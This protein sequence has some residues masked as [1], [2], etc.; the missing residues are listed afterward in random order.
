MEHELRE[1][2]KIKPVQIT[3]S[4][5]QIDTER[6]TFKVCT[7]EGLRIVA[8]Y[9]EE[10]KHRVIAVL[11]DPENRLIKVSGIGEFQPD[12]TL[13]R[14]VEADSITIAI[15]EREIEPNAPTISEMIDA[16]IADTPPEA[17]KG[18]PTDLSHRHDF[19]IHGVD[20]SWK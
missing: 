12:G 8:P 18:V 7:S 16:L 11:Q 17:W 20:T 14:V 3:G 10:N 15:P 6:H 13:K 5:I 9:S 19:Y 1:S 4:I 2:A